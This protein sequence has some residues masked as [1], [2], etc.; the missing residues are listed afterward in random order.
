ML[1]F[2]KNYCGTFFKQNKYTLFNA[3]FLHIF[4][5]EKI[6]TSETLIHVDGTK[7]NIHTELGF[8]LRVNSNEFIKKSVIAQNEII[9]QKLWSKMMEMY[10]TFIK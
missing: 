1:L 9:L 10:K 8:M 6:K 5:W 3:I 2:M 4:K 7:K